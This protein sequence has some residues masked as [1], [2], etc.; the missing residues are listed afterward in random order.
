MTRGFEV[1]QWDGQWYIFNHEGL[2]AEGPFP[3]KAL[4]DEQCARVNAGETALFAADRNLL[5]TI[6]ENQDVM[7]RALNRLVMDRG[8]S[9]S[10]LAEHLDARREATRKALGKDK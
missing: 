8:F 7:M 4:A 6:L 9:A 5:I 3:T 2:L 1:Q 10:D